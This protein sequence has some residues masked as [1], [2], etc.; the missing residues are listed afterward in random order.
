MKIGNIEIK[1]SAALA[2][3]AGVAGPLFP[4]MSGFYVITQHL[5]D[6]Q[7]LASSRLQFHLARQQNQAVERLHSKRVEIRA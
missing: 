1:N 7:R 4:S 2:P 3:M 5:S 6:D